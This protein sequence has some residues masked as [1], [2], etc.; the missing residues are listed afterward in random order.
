MNIDKHSI[1]DIGLDIAFLGA[2]VSVAGSLY[3]N[4]YLD[5]YTAM[6]IWRWSN[7]ILLVYFVGRWKKWWDGGLSDMVMIGLYG[8]YILTNELGLNGITLGDI[9]V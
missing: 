8:W 7:L 1:R 6:L 2:V 5:H 3:N 4:L 9:N